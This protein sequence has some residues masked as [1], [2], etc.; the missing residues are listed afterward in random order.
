MK[1][2]ENFIEI[3]KNTLERLYDENELC[4][5]SAIQEE[6]YPYNIFCDCLYRISLIVADR[7]TNLGIE[8]TPEKLEKFLKGDNSPDDNELELIQSIVSPFTKFNPSDYEKSIYSFV[9]NAYPLILEYDNITNNKSVNEK[10]KEFRKT[11]SSLGN[12]KKLK[13]YNKLK[14]WVNF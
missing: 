7:Y 11:I 12:Q 3:V 5:T 9:Y 1:N 10:I 13:L 4:I 8:L 2:S 14:N 6:A